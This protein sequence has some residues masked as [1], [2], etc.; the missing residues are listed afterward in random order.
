MAAMRCFAGLICWLSLTAADV[1]QLHQLQEQNR[2]FQLREA[3][4]Q[5]GWNDSETL[6]YRAL[7]E[8]RFS[9]ETAAIADLQKFVAAPAD[10]E[11][12]RKAYEEMASA[13]VRMG[14]YG[15][16][17]AAMAEALRLTPADDPDRAD[18]EHNR[19]LYQSLADVAPETV[20][21]GADV[22][23]QASRNPIGS[24]DV[25]VEVNG[26]AGE[27]IFDTGANLT[28]VSESEAARMGLAPRDSG[29]YVKGSTE[30][31]NPLRLAVARDLRFGSALLSN[32]VLLV[33]PD[34]AL[35]IAPL[36]YQIRGILGLPVLRALGCVGIS[37]I[38]EVR[39]ERKETGAVGEPNLF[40]DALYPIVEARHGGQRLEMFLDTGANASFGYPSLRETL[41]PVEIARL[42]RKRDKTGAVGGTVSRKTE[43][44]P[45]LRL[46]ILGRS[47]ELTN[48][49]LLLKQLTGDSSYR[50]GVLGMDGLSGGFMLDFRAMQLRLD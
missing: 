25:P 3:L 19:E 9:Q 1:T 4:Q 45:T 32:V 38:G 43:V 27:W 39:I 29:T 28:T 31:K 8:S 37:A 40:L 14:R 46:E 33:L 20:E 12:K 7:V 36:K 22:A 16:A 34:E 5:P 50:D 21:F 26:Q 15:D 30:K 2:I 41:M 23:T 6:F 49:S 44:A 11:L 42:K 47:V 13:L 17:A 35:Y 18:S 24:W 48:F 10:A